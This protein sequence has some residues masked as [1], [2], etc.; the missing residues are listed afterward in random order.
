[1]S[2]EAWISIAVTGAAL[3]LLMVTRL[4]TDMVLMGAL[5]ILSVT[6]VL[7]PAEALGGF[8]NSGLI[9]VALMY[10]IAAGISHTGGVDLVID[11]V[12]KQPRTTT[13]ALTRLMLPTAAVNIIFST[14]RYDASR[15][16]KM[17][18]FMELPS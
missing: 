16:G 15:M 6:G 9:T 14:P 12:L 18:C 5:V 1:M 8:S 13:R 4:G 10:V 7:T 17:T 3:A 2:I 11:H